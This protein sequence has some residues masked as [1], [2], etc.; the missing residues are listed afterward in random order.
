MPRQKEKEAGR[1]KE[2]WKLDLH[3]SEV[4]RHGVKKTM[5][6]IQAA[7]AMGFWVEVLRDHLRTQLTPDC[8]I[9]YGKCYTVMRSG[10]LAHKLRCL[11][12]DGE[13][14]WTRVSSTVLV[15]R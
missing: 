7:D 6:A 5:T 13:H 12:A 9:F 8:T 3:T 10:L 11:H 15:V 1:S 4:M 2:V 14:N